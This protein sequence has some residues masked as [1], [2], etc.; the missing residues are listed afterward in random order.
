MI[1][2]PSGTDPAFFR[3]VA[4]SRLCVDSLF[5][6]APGRE[7]AYAIAQAW[8]EKLEKSRPESR[9]RQNVGEYYTIDTYHN[10]VVGT[11]LDLERLGRELRVLADHEEVVGDP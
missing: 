8:P 9:L 3:H 7:R 4:T 6:A 1:L 5:R 11:D 10:T 2:A